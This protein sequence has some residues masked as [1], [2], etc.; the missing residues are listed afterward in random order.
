MMLVKGLIA[1]L[2][3]SALIAGAGAAI[4]WNS[5]TV[6]ISGTVTGMPESVAFSGKVQI[7]T[8]R[9]I[10]PE[11]SRRN[12]LLLQIDFSGVSGVGA[13]SSATYVVEAQDVVTRPL[14]SADVVT[15]TFP[16]HSSS[17]RAVSASR[18]GTAS[19]SLSVD[20]ATGAVTA[21]TASILSPER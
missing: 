19:F 2:A 13:V 21:A 10:D 17:T 15:I 5:A 6:P 20:T 7:Q 18:T 16:F 12:K 8:R 14:A 3:S 4:E 1:L 9:A 11:D